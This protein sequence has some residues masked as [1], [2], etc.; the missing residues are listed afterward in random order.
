MKFS[1]H[2]I[3]FTILTVIITLFISIIIANPLFLLQVSTKYNRLHATQKTPH[4]IIAT[5]NYEHIDLFTI[6]NAAPQ[7]KQSTGRGTYIMTADMLHNKMFD[8]SNSIAN[9]NL[10]CLFVRKNTVK[11]SLEVL[12]HSN[13]CML[14]YSHV[15]QTGAYYICR[16]FKGPI[17]LMKITSKANTCKGHKA[18]QCLRDT[19]RQMFDVT[20]K[21]F[22]FDRK[23]LTK[24]NP[25]QFVRQ[26]ISALYE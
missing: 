25:S 5:H 17:I 3:A 16:D 26:L 4:L 2:S 1:S 11:K 14:L 13:L 7:W 8:L 22:H 6:A 19:Y 9:R 10:K 12:D 21:S 20:Y 23:T 15:S 18:V 24:Q